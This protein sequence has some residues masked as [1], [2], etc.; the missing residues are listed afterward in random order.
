MGGGT[1]VEAEMK[2]RVQGC[3]GLSA[4]ARG[5]FM[6]ERRRMPGCG[7]AEV[8][9]VAAAVLLTGLTGVAYA[10]T[11]KPTLENVEVEPIT[12]W[13]RSSATAI[14][15]GE[16][17]TLTLTC[18]VIETDTTRVVPDQSKLDSSVVQ[19]PPFEV[20]GGSHAED[21]K[22]PGVRF[23]QHEYRL[24]LINESAFGAD[25]EVP[26][27]PITY[28]IESQVVQGEAI[29]GRDL[30]YELKPISV[31]LL[32]VVPTDATDI[33]EA[34]AAAFQAVAA[35]EARG[36]T[37]R[38]VAYALFGLA[39]VMALAALVNAFRRRQRTT[40]TARWM[41]P[42]RSVLAGA[43]G[44][45]S[46]VRLQSRGGWTPE[47]AG[48]AL[49]AVRIGASYLGGH[50]IGQAQATG[51]AADGQILVRRLGRA[52]TLVSGSTTAESAGRGSELYDSLRAF[53]SARYGR[54]DALDGPAL[55]EALDA[56]TRVVRQLQR[57]HSLPAELL[58]SL[59]AALRGLVPGKGA[60]A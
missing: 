11:A 46:D 21:L 57:R 28:R 36:N 48:R 25:V 39:G 42:D 18:A 56:G 1:A 8:R 17:F 47:L 30:T 45:L 4:V 49:A 51:A 55:D 10:Q 31:R 22:V 35:R 52:G 23:I 29:Q 5:E 53:T 3:K 19:L 26:T 41:L 15:S 40:R 38:V 34:P 33:R 14:R 7:S 13:W 27:L 54:G 58:R 50:P 59:T 43:A 2:I 60:A 16:N 20:I 37:L 24:R 44:E 12:C 9:R 32:S 6:R